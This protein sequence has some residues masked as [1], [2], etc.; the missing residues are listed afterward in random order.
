VKM[1]TKIIVILAAFLSL[2]VTTTSACLCLEPSQNSVAKAVAQVVQDHQLDDV[3]QDCGHS[4]DCCQMQ[5][6]SI[7]SADGLPLWGAS[8]IVASTSYEVF[9][10][11]IK[12]REQL[13]SNKCDRAPPVVPQTPVTLHQILLN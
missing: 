7:V 8:E 13:A 5:N 6:S 3:C 2:W 11:A 12:F 4:N 9:A 1:K 10:P